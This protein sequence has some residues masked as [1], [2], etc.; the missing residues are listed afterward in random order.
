MKYEKNKDFPI[1]RDFKPENLMKTYYPKM[2]M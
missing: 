1:L 2:K